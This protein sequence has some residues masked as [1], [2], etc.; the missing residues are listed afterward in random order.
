M[1]GYCICLRKWSALGVFVA[2]AS[3]SVPRNAMAQNAL[4]S[5]RSASELD[6]EDLTRI[7]EDGT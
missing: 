1:S 5:R 7:F 3:A 4:P 2:F 6:P